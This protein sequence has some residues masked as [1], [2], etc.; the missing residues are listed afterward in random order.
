MGGRNDVQ[1]LDF[2]RAPRETA[3]NIQNIEV[4]N[5]T[6][7]NIRTTRT[8]PRIILRISSVRHRE[9]DGSAHLSDQSE[10]VSLDFL[11]VGVNLTYE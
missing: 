6:L 8:T 7:A 9:L 2:K 11:Y 1:V 4:E 5:N 3:Q 10:P